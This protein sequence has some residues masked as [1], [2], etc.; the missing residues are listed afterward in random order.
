VI[1]QLEEFGPASFEL[2]QLTR[3][4]PEAYR[5]I[6]SSLNLSPVVKAGRKAASAFSAIG[7][8]KNGYHLE[9]DLRSSWN[10]KAANAERAEAAAEPPFLG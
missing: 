6:A 8:G 3:I 1:G 5:A 7:C 2:T 10:L 9:G 4:P